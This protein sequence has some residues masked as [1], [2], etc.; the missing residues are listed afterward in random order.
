MLV[1]HG[2]IQQSKELNLYNIWGKHLQGVVL[3]TDV[4]VG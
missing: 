4:E 1:R 3:V 2:L